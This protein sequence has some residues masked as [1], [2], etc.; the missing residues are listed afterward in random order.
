MRHSIGTHPKRKK[1]L[2]FLESAAPAWADTDHPELANG[3]VA[4]VR[5]LR[6]ENEHRLGKA[7][8]KPSRSK[9]R[10]RGHLQS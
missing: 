3:A 7:K 6:A 1:L 10:T 2:R 9:S 8:E 5:A 4:W